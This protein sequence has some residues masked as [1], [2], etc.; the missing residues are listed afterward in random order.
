VLSV[1]TD[2]KI[3]KFAKSQAVFNILRNVKVGE[4]LPPFVPQSPPLTK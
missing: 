1:E 3:P 2:C 4:K